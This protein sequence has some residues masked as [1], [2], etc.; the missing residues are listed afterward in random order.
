ML[1]SLGLCLRQ[2]RQ[3]FNISFLLETVLEWI[4]KKIDITID[5]EPETL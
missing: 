2:H 5:T 3:F 4:N 1:A